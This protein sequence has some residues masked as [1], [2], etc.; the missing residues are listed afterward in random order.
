MTTEIQTLVEAGAATCYEAAQRRGALASSI[1]A[2]T[3]GMSVGG[4]ARPVSCHPGDNLAVHRAVAEAEPGEMLIIDGGGVLVAY[5]GDVLAEAAVARGVLGAV[6]DGG[7]RDLAALA[8]LPFPV[9]AR[10][11]AITGASKLN[12]GRV[13]ENVI[14]GGVAI[15]P[16]DWVVADADGVVAGPASA[17]AEVAQRAEQRVREEE[18]LRTRLRAGELTLDLLNLRDYVPKN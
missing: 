12:P 4:R 5:L 11:S 6:V 10:A 16:G 1:R 13:N 8:E 3:S 7:I 14:C 17:L 9:W 2:L 15:A 18:A